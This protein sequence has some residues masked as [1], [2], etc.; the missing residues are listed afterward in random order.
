MK[1]GNSNQY[2]QTKYIGTAV[3][4]FLFFVLGGIVIA[5]SGH[6]DAKIKNLFDAIYYAV[7]T[8][9]TVGYGD[10]YPVTI[11][12]KILAIF[13]VLFTIGFMGFIIGN[14][15]TKINR[16]MEESKLGQK[17]TDFKNHVIMIGWDKFSK[18]VLDQIILTNFK[19]VV[20][21][22]LKE[23]IDVIYELYSKERVFVV[24]SESESQKTLDRANIREAST[25]FI[26]LPEDLEALVYV[27]NTKKLYPNIDFVVSINNSDLKQTFLNAG[28]THI[29]ARN[30]LASKLVAS[31]VF[32]PEVAT[33]TEDLMSTAINEFD[34]DIQ[35]YY[36]NEKN[37]Y[38]GKHYKE[39]FVDLKNDYNVILIGISK[40][41][42][43]ARQ[44]IYN[45]SK[46][47]VIEEKDYLLV[48]ASG[49]SKK[50]I[51]VA[52][53]AIEGKKFD[54]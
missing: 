52:F 16:Y 46:K 25:L 26:N 20:I 17:G 3:F 28:V 15:T 4:L 8:I 36:V 5:E 2:Y 51:E 32:E 49:M 6:P 48:I 27:L 43:G 39:V 53:G 54:N 45:P 31:Y 12:G 34:Y 37:I 42:D 29:V 30:E 10:F 18:Q 7:V 14:I 44:L 33:F 1:K 38:L 24:Y 11:V 21:T 40:Y 9:G 35:Q 19:V 22:R 50:K 23:E 13:L 41:R 47:I